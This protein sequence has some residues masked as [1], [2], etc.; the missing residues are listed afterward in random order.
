L[1]WPSDPVARPSIDFSR[2]FL[3]IASA[4]SACPT[5]ALASSVSRPTGRA[6]FPCNDGLHRLDQVVE[7]AGDGRQV[8]PA[9]GQAGAARRARMRRYRRRRIPSRCHP[10]DGRGRAGPWQAAD[11]RSRRRRSQ[12]CRRESARVGVGPTVVLQ[13][14]ELRVHVGEVSGLRKPAGCCR[15]PDCAP[16]MSKCRCRPQLFPEG[17]FATIT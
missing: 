11:S 1:N 14:T 7:P 16:E 3:P 17:P 2:C 6:A 8:G 15:C 13:R 4:C 9:A 12:G 5:C 10:P